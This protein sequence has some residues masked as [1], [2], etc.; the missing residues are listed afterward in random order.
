[1][2][3]KTKQRI[4][5]VLVV[6]SLVIILLPLF[7]SKNEPKSA[8]SL[9][10]APPFPDQ[11]TQVTTPTT[12][13]A[14]TDAPVSA[15]TS[16]PEAQNLPIQNSAQVDNSGVNQQPDDVI[17]TVRPSVVDATGSVPPTN[18]NEITN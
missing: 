15:N 3:R 2:E 6:I 1:M 10:Q 14:A 4:L 11:P 17:R 18:V 16:E 9:V 8:T 7:Q 12:T 13:V 5:G